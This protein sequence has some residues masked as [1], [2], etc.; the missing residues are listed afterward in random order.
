MSKLKPE[1]SE[2]LLDKIEEIGDMKRGFSLPHRSLTSRLNLWVQSADVPGGGVR[3]MAGGGR[4]LT[5]LV[6]ERGEDGTRIVRKYK[7]G[8]WE[9][10]VNGTLALCRALCRMRDGIPEWSAKKTHAYLAEL[11]VDGDL[12]VRTQSAVDQHRDTL[13]VLLSSDSSQRMAQLGRFGELLLDE[14]EREWPVEYVEMVLVMSGDKR[15]LTTIT[16]IALETG[17]LAYMWGYMLRKGWISSQEME[18][19]CLWAGHSLA[20]AVRSLFGENAQCRDNGFAQAFV[21]V[22]AVGAA[23]AAAAD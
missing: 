22:A 6:F 5:D 1:P 23:S 11:V 9:R 19:M 3:Y 7:Q 17:A 14:L 16:Q 10:R 13:S 18:N 20:L 15:A 21:A 12:R 4:I 8:E 2:D